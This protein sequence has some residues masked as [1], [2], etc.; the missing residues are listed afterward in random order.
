MPPRVAYWTSS[1]EPEMEAVASEVATLRRQ[2][3]QSVAWGLS[4]RHWALLSRKRGYCFNPRLHL[5]FRATTRIFEPI[6]DLNHIFGR[7]GDWFYLQGAR[8]HPT[9]LTITTPSN[10]VA[11][12]LLERVDRFVIEHAEAKDDLLRVGID[13]SQIRLIYPPV[14]LSRFFPATAPSAPFTVLFA[15]SPEEEGWL[16]ARGIPQILDM[17][18]LRP[19]MHFR[20]LWRPWGNSEKRVRQWI[21]ERKLQNIEVSV[22]CF[23]DMPGEYNKAHV[24]LAPFTDVG[25]SKAVPNSVIESMAC[26]R[27]VIVTKAVGLANLI[28]ENKAG[29]VCAAKSEELVEQLDR[30]AR[31]WDYYS[32]AAR[33][34]AERQFGV[35]RFLTEYQQLYADV[36]AI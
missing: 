14:D 1:F 10:P 16:D 34:L 4:V 25:R 23:R 21:A 18:V 15:S 26:G 7:L 2:F 36:L 13:N 22:G 11:K 6:F 20:L 19:K 3:Q 31:D 5:L 33:K 24:T 32:L 29:I 12:S 9:I 8:K 27:P 30:L 28:D 35:E 17:A